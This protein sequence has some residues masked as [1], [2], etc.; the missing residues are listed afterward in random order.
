MYA[1]KQACNELE[2]SLN[3]KDKEKVRN[4]L[5]EMYPGKKKQPLPQFT[6]PPLPPS[7]YTQGQGI[8]PPNNKFQ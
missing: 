6:P 7:L 3:K 2:E 4:Q 5:P 1:R 8:W